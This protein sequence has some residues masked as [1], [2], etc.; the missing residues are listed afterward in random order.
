MA[1]LRATAIA[2]CAPTELLQKGFPMTFATRPTWKK[3]AIA[4]AMTAALAACGGSFTADVHVESGAK[5]G[6]VRMVRIG[7]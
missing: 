1:T 7:R 3:A 5:E 6:S 2:R 4:L